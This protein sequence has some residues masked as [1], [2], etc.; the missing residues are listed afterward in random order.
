MAADMM[1]GRMALI[2]DGQVFQR[3]GSIGHPGWRCAV[4]MLVFIKM[5]A[6]QEKS[7]VNAHHT[8]SHSK[9]QTGSTNAMRSQPG[10]PSTLL[11]R[12]KFWII[13][14][15]APARFDLLQHGCK[16]RL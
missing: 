14:T 13:A 12:K 2:S 1:Q 6:A 10:Y 9:A 15:P 4:G 5:C 3:N 11:L 7:P 8:P 16:L